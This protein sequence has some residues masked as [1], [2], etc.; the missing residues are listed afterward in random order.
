MGPFFGEGPPLLVLCSAVARLGRRRAA[1]PKPASPL[2]WLGVNSAVLEAEAAAIRVAIEQQSRS[3]AVLR[4][5]RLH[6]P[7]NADLPRGS[8]L[9]SLR[10]TPPIAQSAHRAR[11]EQQKLRQR[12]HG[13][14]NGP[15]LVPYLQLRICSLYTPQAY[16]MYAASPKA[17]AMYGGTPLP[18]AL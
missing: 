14:Q 6:V 7:L 18:I 3:I 15:A 12:P 13:P 8:G 17:C 4:L 10:Y 9:S 16:S 1:R 2:G 5:R 11:H